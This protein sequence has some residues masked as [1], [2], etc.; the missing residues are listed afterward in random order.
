MFL[1]VW[2]LFSPFVLKIGG[3]YDFSYLK[4]GLKNQEK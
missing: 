3:G 2:K 1:A 4:N